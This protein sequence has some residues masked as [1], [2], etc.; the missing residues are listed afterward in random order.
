TG[1]RKPHQ[2][3]AAKSEND[4]ARSS[5]IRKPGAE[6]IGKEYNIALSL[7]C[8]SCH[9]RRV[10]WIPVIDC[11]ADGAAVGHVRFGN[12]V[13]SSMLQIV[14]DHVFSGFELESALAAGQNRGLELLTAVSVISHDS[15]VRL[16]Y[17]AVLR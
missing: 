2:K 6:S 9:G 3:H 11:A 5:G 15:V 14:D 17:R 7:C 1:I 12:G 10:I 13:C 4:H 8:R 16:L